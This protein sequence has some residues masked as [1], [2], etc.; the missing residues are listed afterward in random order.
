MSPSFDLMGAD[1]AVQSDVFLIVE[2]KMH[3]MPAFGKII[4]EIG[5]IGKTDT[6]GF[7]LA[8]AA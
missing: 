4:R 7:D 3:G 8:A 5:G 1:G 6:K 2:C